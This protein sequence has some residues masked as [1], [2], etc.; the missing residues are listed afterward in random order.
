MAAQENA[1]PI[2]VG[3][4]ILVALVVLVVGH[5]ALEHD[6]TLAPVVALGALVLLVGLFALF[7]TRAH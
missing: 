1:K 6:P 3:S 7:L 5:L 4:A 2:E